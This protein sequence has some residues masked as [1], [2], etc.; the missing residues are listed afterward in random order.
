MKTMAEN[1]VLLGR[2]EALEDQIRELNLAGLER[3]IDQIEFRVMQL[4]KACQGREVY[5]TVARGK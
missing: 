2:I 3:R 5:G 4:E 1:P